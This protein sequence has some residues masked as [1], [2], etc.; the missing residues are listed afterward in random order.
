MKVLWLYAHPDPRSLNGSLRD[1]GLRK[2]D[3]L[4]HDYRVSDLYAMGW[5]ATVDSTDYGDHSAGE[6]LVVASASQAAYHSGTLSPDVAAE[7]EKLRWA[8]TV[9]VQFPLWWY[10]MPAILKGWFDRVFVKGFAYGVTDPAHPGRTLRYGQGPLSGKRVLTVLTSGSPE[11]PLGPRGINGELH[12]VLFPL[13]HGTFWYT[14]MS[15]LPPLAVY[16]ADRLGEQGYEH[17]AALLRR[18]LESI[19]DIEPLPYRQQNSGD[20]D[21]NLVLRPDLAPGRSGL[22]VHYTGDHPVGDGGH[23]DDESQR[24]RAAAG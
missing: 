19:E 6:R 13:L 2:L 7:Q 24:L 8:D 18:R 4:G 16:A 3:E 21:D 14:G 10:G 17:Y 1:A 22:G 15:V 20:Y 11:A 12:H 9:V 5:K 23:P